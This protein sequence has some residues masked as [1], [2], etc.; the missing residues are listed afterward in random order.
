MVRKVNKR[1]W[2][3]VL[4]I[5][6]NNKS[7]PRE[8]ID[9]EE[10][11]SN[12]YEYRVVGKA[13]RRRGYHSSFVYENYLYIHGGHDIREGTLEKM[14]R[15]NL[16]PKSNDNEWEIIQQ[17]GVEQ[18]GKVGYHTLTRYGNK[19]YLIGGSDLGK[20][21][22]KMYEFNIDTNEWKVVNQ[23]DSNN[24]PDPRDEHSAVLWND[25][26]VIYGGNVHGFKS[27]ELWFYYCNDNKRK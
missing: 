16:E 9:L 7:P 21:N 27:S 13:P 14:Y 3:L 20:D 19:V 1:V 25:I 6:E 17:R 22:T 8:N 18:P 24:F 4:K 26:I 23:K 15:I 5:V 2:K 11:N 10:T 12:W